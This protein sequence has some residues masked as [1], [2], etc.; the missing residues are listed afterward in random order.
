MIFSK[1]FPRH[2]RREIGR[3]SS[4]DL[5]FGFPFE[6]GVILAIFQLFGK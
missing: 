4:G 3:K 1:H 5:Q 2:E 6:I